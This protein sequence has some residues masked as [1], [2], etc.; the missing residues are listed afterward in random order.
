MQLS[1][2]KFVKI[3]HI[4]ESKFSGETGLNRLNGIVHPKSTHPQAILGD[5]TFFFQVNPI[6]VIF[7]NVLALPSFIMAVNGCYFS[8]VQKKSNK[9][10]QSIIMKKPHMDLGGE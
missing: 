7:K 3:I 1:F 9:A 8:I 10:H 5:M 2:K 4:N 6:R